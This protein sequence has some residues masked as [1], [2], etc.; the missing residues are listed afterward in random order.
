MHLINREHIHRHYC[1]S[2]YDTVL[3]VLRTLYT[4]THTPHTHTCMHTCRVSL[5]AILT[6]HQ[7]LRAVTVTGVPYV[8]LCIQVSTDVVYTRTTY[9]NIS[10]IKYLTN[11]IPIL[12]HH[13]HIRKPDLLCVIIRLLNA[14]LNQLF[15][16]S[17]ITFLCYL[18]CYICNKI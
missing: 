17:F 14:L 6:H 8:R 7:N 3:T 1:N 9:C 2:V 15:N 18:K 13:L 4:H 16:I 12:V 10:I 11:D 5:A